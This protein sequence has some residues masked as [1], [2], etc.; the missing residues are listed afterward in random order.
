MRDMTYV[1]QDLLTCRPT[2]GERK[3]RLK[4]AQPESYTPSIDNSRAC[5]SFKGGT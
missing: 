5:F 1:E 4:A 2:I 3:L